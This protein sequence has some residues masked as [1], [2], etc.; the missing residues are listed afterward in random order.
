MPHS[1]GAIFSGVGFRGAT[2]CAPMTFTAPK[3]APRPIIRRIGTHGFIARSLHSGRCRR[4]RR[5][6]CECF[7]KPRRT[8]ECYHGRRPPSKTFNRVRQPPVL[9]RR[10][11]DEERA[12][13]KEISLKTK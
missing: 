1:Y 11:G 12:R 13:V 10:T 5:H 3:P 8:P 2:R 9:N 6:A 4:A 7:L